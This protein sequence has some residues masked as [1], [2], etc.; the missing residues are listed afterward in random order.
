[1]TGALWAFV[2]IMLAILAGVSIVLLIVAIDTWRTHRRLAAHRR[3]WRET[4]RE[5]ADG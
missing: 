5:K 1:M 3:L 2:V 4:I